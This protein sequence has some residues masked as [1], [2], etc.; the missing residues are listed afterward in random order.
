MEQRSIYWFDLEAS[1]IREVYMGELDE[2]IPFAW[3][4]HMDYE[5]PCRLLVGPS[6]NVETKEACEELHCVPD[7]QWKGY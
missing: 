4:A 2:G 7:C 1:N 6:W 3:Q 5:Y